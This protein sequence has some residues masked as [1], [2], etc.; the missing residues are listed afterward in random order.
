M[1]RPLYSRGRILQYAL[2]TTTWRREKYCPLLKT[3][4]DSSFVQPVACRYTD[5]TTATLPRPARSQPL[6]RPRYC[7]SAN[8]STACEILNS[9]LES[10]RAAETTKQ[11][12][13][14]LQEQLPVLFRFQWTE[15]R[16]WYMKQE[17]I[18]SSEQSL[19]TRV[20]CKQPEVSSFHTACCCSI[21]RYLFV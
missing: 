15:L 2:Y 16:T 6:Y 5:R 4:F 8:S 13:M 17:F 11:G 18:V 1:R 20:V 14:A 9:S 3:T 10:P 12:D 19:S 7:D 21:V